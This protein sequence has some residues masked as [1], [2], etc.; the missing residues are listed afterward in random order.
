[1]DGV[2]IQKM[3]TEGIETIVGVSNDPSFGHSNHVRDGW[4]QCR[5][6]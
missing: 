6:A 3:V 4:G 1:M 5:I 2:M